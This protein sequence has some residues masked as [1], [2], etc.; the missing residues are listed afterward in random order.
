MKRSSGGIL[1]VREQTTIDKAI[2][3]FVKNRVGGVIVN[4]RDGEILY[5]DKRII[6][7]DKGKGLFNKKRPAVDELKTW[8]FTDMDSGKYY[9]VETAFVEV[10]NEGC[11]CHL[12]TDVRDYATLFQDISDYSKRISDMSDFQKSILAK[13][14]QDYDCCLP[15]LTVFCRATDADLYMYEDG[16]SH[17]R[18]SSYSRRLHRVNL[19]VSDELEALFDIKRFGLEDGYYCFLSERAGNQ[20]YAVFLR[21]G[22]DFN[23][24]YFRD[25]SVYNVIRLYIEN[26]ILREKIIYESEHDGLTGLYNKGKYMSLKEQAFGA[27]E[28]I[29]V[30]NFD[31]NNLKTV[32]DSLGHEAGDRLLIIAADSLK[33][34]LSEDVMGFRLGGDEF[35][36]IARGISRS[37][38]E[39]LKQEWEKSLERMNAKYKQDVTIACGTAYG[40]GEYDLDILL[41][42][43]DTRMYEN[44]KAMK[45][46]LGLKT[47]R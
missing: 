22:H 20:R 29:A 39:D 31:V 32:N 41:A 44:K 15:E 36:V 38:A 3:A 34:I 26:G 37:E 10:D 21:R 4:D 9:R 1:L 2:Q 35:L 43:A 46:K 23:E 40:D 16:S 25:A 47:G 7:S 42:D 17:V 14:S 33:D 5:K 30:F 8:E 12:F 6:L 24:E 45:E 19:P 18:R 27:P 28:R 13:L 11:Q